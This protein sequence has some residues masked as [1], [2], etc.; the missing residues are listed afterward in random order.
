MKKVTTEKMKG[1]RK[2]RK[3][4]KSS[5]KGRSKEGSQV[6]KMKKGMKKKEKEK[7]RKEKK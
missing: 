7:K 2:K 4:I 1:T 6:I 5:N 3:E